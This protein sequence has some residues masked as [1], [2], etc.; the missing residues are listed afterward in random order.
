MSKECYRCEKPYTTDLPAPGLSKM[1]GSVKFKTWVIRF[2]F[3]R[4]NTWEKATTAADVIDTSF[5]TEVE[6]CSDC[7]GDV[8][9][10]INKKKVGHDKS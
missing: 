6:L 8:L 9:S 10:F 5:Y 3:L 4:M 7:W 1:W 2:N